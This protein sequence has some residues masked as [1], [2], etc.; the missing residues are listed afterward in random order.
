MLAIAGAYGIVPIARRT[1][2]GIRA[3]RRNTPSHRPARQLSTRAYAVRA[4]PRRQHFRVLLPWP[5]LFWFYGLDDLVLGECGRHLPAR[6]V[7][8]KPDPLVRRFHNRRTRFNLSIGLG[9][10][11]SR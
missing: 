2:G 8:P 4:S 9:H 5:C 7:D 6:C 3:C 10:Q 11:R 1:L